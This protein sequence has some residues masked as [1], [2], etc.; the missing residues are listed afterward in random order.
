[1]NEV[2]LNKTTH[3]ESLKESS[4]H[5]IDFVNNLE[6]QETSRMF[7]VF[8]A[9]TNCTIFCICAAAKFSVP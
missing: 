9:P 8:F 5:R 2:I 1:M 4:L 7:Y 3:D 6:Q